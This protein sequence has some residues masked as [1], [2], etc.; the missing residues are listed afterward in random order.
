MNEE[1]FLNFI[2]DDVLLEDEDFESQVDNYIQILNKSSCLHSLGENMED[3]C[4]HCQWM[5]RNRKDTHSL[6][7][8]TKREEKQETNVLR[9]SVSYFL[10][11]R[12]FGKLYGGSF[13]M[14]ERKCFKVSFQSNTTSFTST[15]SFLYCK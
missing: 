13:E 9:L 6:K 5:L 10:D 8:Q 15:T 12:R 3:D 14:F 7:I 1:K 2:K 4:S 11:G